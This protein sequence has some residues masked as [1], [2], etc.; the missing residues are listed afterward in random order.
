MKKLLFVAALLAMATVAQAQNELNLTV[1]NIEFDGTDGLYTLS[2]DNSMEIAGWS[3]T[4]FAPEGAEVVDFELS[5]RYEVNSR[6]KPYHSVTNTLTSEGGYLLICYAADP[7]HN[8]ISG[9]S[10]ELGTIVVD[11]SKYQGEKEKAEIFINGFSVSDR[12]GSQYNLNEDITVGI[13]S[14]VASAGSPTEAVYNLQGQRVANSHAKGVYIKN[15]K[16]VVKM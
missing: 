2:L 1:S 12:S 16:K 13:S 8:I 9:N 7:E 5:D 14:V 4:V 11:L 6:K 10:G 3:M 15:G